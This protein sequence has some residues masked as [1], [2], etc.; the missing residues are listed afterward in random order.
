MTARSPARKATRFK[1]RVIRDRLLREVERNIAIHIA[2]SEEK[3]AFEVSGR[4]ELQL[5][6]LIETMR[7]EGFELTVSRPR[8][9]FKKDEATGQRLEP[10]EEVIIDVDDELWRGRPEAV[11]AQGR[12]DRNAPLRRWP[13]SACVFLM[14]TRGLIGYQSELLTD[15]R[16]TAIM[17]RLFHNMRRSRVASS[18]ATPAC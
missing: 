16:G 8:V 7:R 17:N 9:V 15:T 14:P 4:G 6:I 11:R 10:I 13:H 12:P 5:A 18:A 2:E 1:A 3:D